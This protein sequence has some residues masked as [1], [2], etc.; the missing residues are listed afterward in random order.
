MFLWID[1]VNTMAD[2]QLPN[3]AIGTIKPVS[4]SWSPGKG[5]YYSERNSC[6]KMSGQLLLPYLQCFHAN[7]N[8]MVKFV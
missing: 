2:L 6:L 5:F 7:K 1:F 3:C 8:D 4:A